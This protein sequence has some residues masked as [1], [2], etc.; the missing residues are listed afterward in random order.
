MV[1]SEEDRSVEI[2]RKGRYE[3]LIF[4]KP[5]EAIVFE[6]DS[7]GFYSADALVLISEY[8]MFG[9]LKLI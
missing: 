2:G 8:F 1:E 3:I 7:K 4:I 9:N 5:F 6:N